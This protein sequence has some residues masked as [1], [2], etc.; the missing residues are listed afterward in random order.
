MTN[1]M[2]Q[3]FVR[4]ARL[5]SKA[6]FAALALT[7]AALIALVIASRDKDTTTVKVLSPVTNVS[8]PDTSEPASTSTS[9]LVPVV[10]RVPVVNH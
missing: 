3:S 2:P 4:R 7:L 9:A 6:I 8:S 10:N 1:D 5:S